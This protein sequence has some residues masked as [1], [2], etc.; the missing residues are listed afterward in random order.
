MPK[1]LQVSFTPQEFEAFKP[2]DLADTIC[3]VFDIFRATSTIVTALANGAKQVIP[4]NDIPQAME[5]HR[6]HQHALLAGE[7]EGV[8]ITAKLTGSVDFDL[9]NS[10]REFV[11]ETVQD[12]TI[13]ITTTNGSRAL[14]ACESSSLCLAA[15]FLNL[16]STAELIAKTSSKR[17]LLVCSG[18]GEKTAYEDVLGAGAMIECL[19]RFENEFSLTDSA[20]IALQTYQHSISNISEA[21]KYSQN[22]R[23]LLSIPELHDDVA[24]CLQR[25]TCNFTAIYRDGMIRKD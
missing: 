15:S 19:L 8:R 9:G 12:K 2:A 4:V 7:R 18:T 14:K 17:C 13:I 24:Y 11:R 20:F 23:R 25:D 1:K 3:V 10:P 22:G 21:V 16:S 6:L 5:M